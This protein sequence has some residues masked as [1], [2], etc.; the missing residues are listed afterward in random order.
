MSD[1]DSTVNQVGVPAE[2]RLSADYRQESTEDLSDI[3]LPFTVENVT[4]MSPGVWN[5]VEYLS[6][7]IEEA[8]RRTNWDDS[9]VVSMFNEHDDEDSRDWIGEVRNVRMEGEELVADIDVVTAEE[10]RKVAYGA[11]FGISPKVAG[12]K[13]N[14]RMRKYRYQNF[15]LVLDPAVKTTF[16]NE[17]QEGSDDTNDRGI[18]NVKV[19]SNMSDDNTVELSEEDQEQLSEI[20]STVED[21]DVEDLAEII[22]PFMSHSAEDLEPQIEEA[23]S[24][25]DD[26][27]SGDEEEMSEHVSKEEVKEMA[28]EAAQEAVSEMK[29][30]MQEE[31]SDDDGDEDG[32]DESADE[33]EESMSV[34]DIANEVAD[35]L[36]QDT[37]EMSENSDDGDEE[38]EAVAEL[39]DELEEVKE[40][41]QSTQ[42]DS[43]PN[44]KTPNPGSTATGASD[45]DPREKV[46]ELDAE[47]LDKGAA[48]HLLRTQ[49]Q[50]V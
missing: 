26:S 1:A 13:K 40:Q 25:Q 39:K 12:R 34:D 19:K 8:Y 48:K 49:R 35:R 4:L 6:S 50:R 23:M 36:E 37:E 29:E 47:E 5:N 22:S 41:L 33:A 30:A 15:S 20:V 10:A 14:G 45:Q 17:E 42:N 7:E 2:H 31:M 28:R 24:E 18:K 11:R 16:L 9:D 44:E 21:A 43:N 32:V 27:D 46:E 38:S 3:S